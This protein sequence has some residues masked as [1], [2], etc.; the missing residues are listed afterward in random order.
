MDEAAA[1]MAR[2]NAM[3]RRAARI[4][5][6]LPPEPLPSADPTTPRATSP[7][8]IAIQSLE[9]VPVSLGEQPAAEHPADAQPPSG[10][11]AAQ[12]GR[13]AWPKS[14]D[15]IEISFLSDFR[16][17]ISDGGKSEAC[18][19]AEFGFEDGRSEKPNLAWET[20][21]FLAENGGI[22][23][24]PMKTNEKWTQVEKRIQTIRKV[25]CEY[26]RI[27]SDPIPYIEG[28]GYKS[29]FK[30]RLSGILSTLE[31][32][33]FASAKNSANSFSS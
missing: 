8:P 27:S 15:G 14:W 28:T 22:L 29:I 31:R 11:R 32:F 13:K 24:Q 19:Y 6:G 5:A 16:V 17:Q 30:I 1:V 20:L 18:S 33:F 10:P 4:A 21:R 12:S 2:F 3:E 25:L 7:M 23:N 26:F 9:A